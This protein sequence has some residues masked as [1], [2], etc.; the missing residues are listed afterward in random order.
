MANN[1][2]AQRL[3][4]L[5]TEKGIKREDVAAALNCSVSA[6]GN[7]ENGNR[8]PDFDGLIKL[9]DLF[10]TTTDYLL[11]RTDI[12]TSDKNV[13]FVCKYTGLSEKAVKVLHLLSEEKTSSLEFEKFLVERIKESENSQIDNDIIT[14]GNNR[15][16]ADYETKAR[17]IDIVSYFIEKL[18]N[19]YEILD[20]LNDIIRLKYLNGGLA[21]AR[22]MEDTII[23]K[24]PDLYHYIYR[25]SILLTG[26]E[27]RTYLEEKAV[28]SFRILVCDFAFDYAPYEN[29]YHYPYCGLRTVQT[30]EERVNEMIKF[31]NYRMEHY[32]E[33]EEQLKSASYDESGDS[34]GNNTEEE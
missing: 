2:F 13:E 9:A 33:I 10:S 3:T 29:E 1:S 32:D 21:D 12:M 11:G 22:E 34:N 30:L 26:V 19:A 28:N 20:I 23:D 16:S 24:D 31:H 8:T 5:R 25:H 17:S 6:V 18:Y 15:V 14:D 4:Q 27:Y 7:Y